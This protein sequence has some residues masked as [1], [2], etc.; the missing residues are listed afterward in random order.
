M[1]GRTRRHQVLVVDDDADVRHQLAHFLRSK[2]HTPIEVGTGDAARHW[3]QCNK[4]DAMVIDVTIP[5]SRG[6]ELVQELRSTDTWRHLPIL[7]VSPIHQSGE[8]IRAIGLGASDYIPKPFEPDVLVAK[9]ESH[10]RY[11]E[12]LSRLRKQNELLGRLAV[13]DEL[14]QLYNRRAFMEALTLEVEHTAQRDKPCALLFV[15][16]DL[17]KNVNDTYGHL[18]GDEVLQQAARRLESAVREGDI[19]GRFGGEEFCVVIPD[20]DLD[21]ALSAGERLRRAIGEKPFVLESGEPIRLTTSVGI[22]WMPAGHN[23]CPKAMIQTA[24]ESM[25]NAKR[26]GR[27]RVYLA[28]ALSGTNCESG[29]RPWNKVATP[30]EE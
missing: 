20:V 5:G 1:E 23:T 9:L 18:A 8:L 28:E 17:F 3:M 21:L 24:D 14:T 30:S 7:V 19:L 2:G 11:H 6:L 26:L 4:V 27:N 13:L 10:L 25:Y 22:A 15:D 29:E 12:L 16:L